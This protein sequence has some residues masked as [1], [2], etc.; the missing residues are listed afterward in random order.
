MTALLDL[1]NLVCSRTLHM[2][3]LL[4][5]RSH[6]VGSSYRRISIMQNVYDEQSSTYL[7][8]LESV[9]PELGLPVVQ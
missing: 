2:H 5:N 3:L 1:V 6:N 7:F 4:K 9:T 8:D